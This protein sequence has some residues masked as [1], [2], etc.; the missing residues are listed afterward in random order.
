M[1]K[2]IAIILTIALLFSFAALADDYK[3][4]TDEEL[5]TA[6]KQIR[7]E[8]N[9]RKLNTNAIK[10]AVLFESNGVKVYISDNY[11]VSGSSYLYL[12]I[13]IVNDND[14]E[15]SIHIESCIINGWDLFVLGA[16]CKPNRKSKEELYFDLKDADCTSAADIEDF[17]IQFS[18]Y[19]SDSYRTVCTLPE[20]TIKL[21]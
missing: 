17:I 8:L 11:R 9:A 20:Q 4:M 7:A 6:M 10:N 2:L 19:D 3:A 18:I 16:S 5:F 13:V 1:K 21:Y 12:P 15:V 14:F